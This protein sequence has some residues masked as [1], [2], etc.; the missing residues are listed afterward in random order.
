MDTGLHLR[1]GL[2]IH[3]DSD[4]N[5]IFK[6]ARENKELLCVNANQVIDLQE[7]IQVHFEED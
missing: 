2:F 7:Y 4:G 5:L 6:D 1:G 3:F